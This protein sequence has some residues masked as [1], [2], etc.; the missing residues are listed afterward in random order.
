VSSSFDTDHPEQ[1]SS[2]RIPAVQYLRIS[3]EQQQHSIENQAAVLRE[4][5]IQR[6]FSILGTIAEEGKSGLTVEDEPRQI[7]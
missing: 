2:G 3:T 6:G 1:G 4:Y 5:A 7:K